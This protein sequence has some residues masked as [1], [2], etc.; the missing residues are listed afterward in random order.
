M[1]DI[2]NKLAWEKMAGL[3]P[4]IIQNADTLQVLL[5]GYM[6][7]QA[8]QKTI[9]EKKVTFYSRSKQ[10]L[11]QK[12]ETSGNILS[13]VDII[14][15][16]DSDALLVLVNPAGPTCH[17][18]TPSCFGEQDAAGVG[19]LAQLEKVI[20]ERQAKPSAESYTTKLFEKGVNY[21]EQKVG[22]EAVES[23]IAAVADEDKFADE[24][25]DL[26]YHLLVLLQEKKMRL[27]DVIE[28][29]KQRS[30]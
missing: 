1:Q 21:I 15:D 18:N 20:A 23:V 27:V 25:A 28:I 7:R 19:W 11:W 26:I 6:N 2:I 16:C 12:G 9:A 5:V 24:V 13:V 29:L 8:L 22:E 10:R 4:A 14:A 17:R 30:R 3:I